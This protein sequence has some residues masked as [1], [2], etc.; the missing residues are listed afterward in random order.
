MPAGRQHNQKKNQRRRRELPGENSQQAC[1]HFRL[2]LSRN[3]L[4]AIAAAG[5]IEILYI[6]STIGSIETWYSVVEGV[7]ALFANYNK[8]TS[9]CVA[10]IVE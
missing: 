5:V 2:L 1:G 8:L 9:R 6:T 4:T 10:V 3:S 7:T